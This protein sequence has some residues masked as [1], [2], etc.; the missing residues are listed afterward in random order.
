MLSFAAAYSVVLK[1]PRESSDADVKKA[2]HI[3]HAA[4]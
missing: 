4:V 3:I 1:V 2:K